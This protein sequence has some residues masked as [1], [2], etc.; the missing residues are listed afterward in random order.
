VQNFALLNLIFKFC[1]KVLDLG[2]AIWYIYNTSLR[3]LFL[4]GQKVCKNEERLFIYIWI[5]AAGDFS[6]L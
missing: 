3:S 6:L 1:K 4:C 5:V 2:I